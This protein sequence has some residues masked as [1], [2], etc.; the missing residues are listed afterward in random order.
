LLALRNKQGRID[1]NNSKFEQSKN[2]INAPPLKFI[3]V[4]R[5]S[6]V[7]VA[8]P[9]ENRV[10]RPAVVASNSDRTSARLWHTAASRGTIA[11]AERQLAASS[12]CK[13]TESNGHV[14][15]EQPADK[16]RNETIRHSLK[17]NWF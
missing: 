2:A 15:R 7:E 14:F 5:G 10:D 13:R 1:D 16:S 12:L 3:G 11:T 6:T 17:Y 9:E 8:Q 4:L